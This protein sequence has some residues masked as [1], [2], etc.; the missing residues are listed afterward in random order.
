MTTLSQSA[1]ESDLWGTATILRGLVDA[2]DDKQFVFPLLFYKRLS[3]VGDEDSA[4]A[5]HESEGDTA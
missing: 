5:M 2:G 1:H 4:D 3:D